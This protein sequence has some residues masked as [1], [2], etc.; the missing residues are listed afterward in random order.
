MSDRAVVLVASA[1]SLEAELSR[2]LLGRSDV[3]R[4]L[5]TGLGEAM[6]AAA[7]LRPRLVVIDRD[8]PQAVD[9]VGA[10]RR[11]PVTRRTSVVVVASAEF[12]PAE[13]EFLELGANAILRLPPTGEWDHRLDRL[14][15]VPARREARFGMTL[16]ME[17]GFVQGPIEATAL[18]LSL[19]GM[20]VESEAALRVGDEV[21]FWFGLPGAA[22]RG[23][24]RIVR[25]GARNTFGVA[26]TALDGA[27][28]EA[29]RRH[30]SLLP[31][32]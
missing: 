28:R 6:A 1:G 16:R 14:M 7:A 24:G 32:S 18:N 20:L 9:L 4:H 17:T 11:D 12:E 21:R 30:V 22:V 19:H 3:E 15:N 5:A 27:G 25:Q 26:F 10:L 13:V 29:I 23:G 8:M 31:S 2:T